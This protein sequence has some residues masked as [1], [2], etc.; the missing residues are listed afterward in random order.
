[1]QI[2]I[3]DHAL[4]SLAHYTLSGDLSFKRYMAAGRSRGETSEVL[5]QKVQYAQRQQLRMKVDVQH[6]LQAGDSMDG[7]RAHY[8]NQLVPPDIVSNT[9]TRLQQKHAR[10][11]ACLVKPQPSGLS[12]NGIDV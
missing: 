7:V 4:L 12:V 11:R 9:I 2:K 1:M 5:R 8:I 10:E 3:E 6:C